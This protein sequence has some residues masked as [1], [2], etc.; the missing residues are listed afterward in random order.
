[1][2]RFSRA[3]LT[4]LAAIGVAVCGQLSFLLLI[5]APLNAL[6]DSSVLLYWLLP[7]LSASAAVVSW[8]LFDGKP[9][10]A[11]AWGVTIGVVLIHGGLVS[12][13]ANNDRHSA[14]MAWLALGP[15]F[16]GV[17]CAIIAYGIGALASRR[18]L[19]TSGDER[20]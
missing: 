11:K 16:S 20:A 17:P 7:G 18:F 9:T 2:L 15:V 10:W 8:L 3:G 6:I 5:K 19:S 13:F 14:G 4:L 1:M 12:Y